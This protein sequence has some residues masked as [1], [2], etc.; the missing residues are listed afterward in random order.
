M[1][2]LLLIGI[3]AAALLV[4]GRKSE[5]VG[6]HDDRVEFWEDAERYLA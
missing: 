5:P 4:L 6:T 3:G 1:N 2:P